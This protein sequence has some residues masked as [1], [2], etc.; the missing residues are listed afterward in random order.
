MVPPVAVGNVELF[1][2]A[3]VELG[4]TYERGG[5]NGT[6]PLEILPLLG[7]YL[8][9]GKKNQQ[10]FLSSLP[11]RAPLKS[12]HMSLIKPQLNHR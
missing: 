8:R 1:E 6:S 7:L 12:P 5:G 4:E 9:V 2:A 10:Q 11:D 3:S